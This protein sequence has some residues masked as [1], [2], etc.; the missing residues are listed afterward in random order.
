M[1]IA[2]DT[3]LLEHKAN[4]VKGMEWIRDNLPEYWS[5]NVNW[6]TTF[7]HDWSKS[8]PEEYDAY[9]AY[10]YGHNRSWIVVNNFQRAWLHHIHN[11]PHHW[12]HWVL[13][14]DDEGMVCINM[15]IGYIV[16]M[17]CDW[18]SFSWQTE[19]LST[20]FDWY[21]EHKDTMKLHKDT[22]IMVEDILGRIKEK[23]EARE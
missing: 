19:N 12:Q 9:D 5:Q 18:W 13:I 4:V 8:S 17:I 3:Y 20:I 16:E 15:P 6:L 11:N 21:A 7:Q 10:F 1:S 14:N 23:L 22:R 2:Y